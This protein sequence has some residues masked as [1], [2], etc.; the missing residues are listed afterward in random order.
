MFDNANIRQALPGPLFSSTQIP[1]CLWFL[2][3]NKNTDA[4]RGC[5]DRRRPTDTGLA[6]A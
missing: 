2:A 1:V 4:K 6:K 3:K 5:R